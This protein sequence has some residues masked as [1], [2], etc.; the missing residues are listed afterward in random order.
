MEV[1]I[2]AAG[3][4]SRLAGVSKNQPKCL[5]KAGNE[6]LIK[7]IIR[8]CNEK[9]LYNIT[10][11]TGYKCKNIEEELGNSVTYIENPFYKITNSI[12]SLWLARE[13]LVGDVL[14]MNAD[15]FFE[16][17]ILD[18]ALEQ[19]ND[20]VMLADST[21]I[22]DADYRFSFNNDTIVRYGKELSNNETDGEYVGIVRID[23]TFI[24]DFIKRLKKMI[25]KGLVNDWWE[26]VL[27]SFIENGKKIHYHD[28]KGTFWTEVDYLTDYIRL[29]DWTSPKHENR[30]SDIS[31]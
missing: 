16:A 5:I 21:R 13:Y 19:R 26:N 23:K 12:S 22:V 6:S 10:V 9:G 20:A 7:R 30:L 24:D 14:L 28:V 15:L 18:M 4:G 17:G 2:M 29:Q 3:V 31:L 11:V 27:Y 25:S 8:I 1:I